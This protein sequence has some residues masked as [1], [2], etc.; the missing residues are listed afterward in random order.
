RDTLLSGADSLEQRLDFLRY[1]LEELDTL[2]LQPGEIEQLEAELKRLSHADELMAQGHRL[3][4]LLSD[5]EQSAAGALAQACSRLQSLSRFEPRLGSALELFEQA[6]INLDEGTSTLR[7][8]LDAVEH[9]EAR[10]A[11][12]ESR[13]SAAH[14]LA[15]KHRVQPEAL[16]ERHSGL[17]EEVASLEQSSQ[18]LREIDTALGKASEAYLRCARKLSKARHGAARQL[19]DRVSE[20]LGTLG[21]AGARLAVEVHSADPPRVT[22]H[23]IDEVELTVATNPG[24]PFQ[25]IGRV[26]SGGELSRIAL[27]IQVVA[28][29]D[30]S[31]PTLVFDE[32]DVGV[33]GKTAEVVGRNL[34]ALA[35]TRQVLCVTHLPQVASQAHHQLLVHKQSERSATRS[36]LEPL[37][38]ETRVR[39]LA[40]MLAGEEITEQA[41]AHARDLLER[42]ARASADPKAS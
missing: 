5:D 32:V 40:R 26:A 29:H 25:P 24:Q 30:S 1:Q 38:G 2:A 11:E 18:R 21:M 4:E 15:R 22:A 33:G 17:S 34:R 42:A 7:D 28:V 31:V 23:G 27:A 6:R 8:A 3:L 16:C 13:L 41:L 35:R 19:A 14:E 12:V 9:N 10:Q 37:T 39:E 36:S 20:R